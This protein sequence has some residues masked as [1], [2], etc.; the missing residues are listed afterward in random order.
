M[1]AGKMPKTIDC[2]IKDDLIDSCISG[3]IITICGIMKTELQSDM[4]GFG[5]SRGGANKNRA[6][7]SSYID[8]NSV[9]SSN[10]EFFLSSVLG[11]SGGDQNASVNMADQKMNMAELNLIHKIAER[12]DL[13]PLLVKSV[14]PSIFGN[15]VVKCGQLLALFGGTDYRLKSK[16]GDFTEF[17]SKD[18]KNGQVA[19]IQ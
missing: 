5:G 12:R 6:L 4:K 14:C 9:R 11:S 3:D 13:F 2:E 1:N 19:Q 17:L 10:S 8:V 7:H 18:D 15:E 16:A